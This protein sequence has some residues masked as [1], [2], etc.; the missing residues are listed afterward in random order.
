MYTNE[1]EV[2][3]SQNINFLNMTI[4]QFIT[5]NTNFTLNNGDLPFPIYKKAFKKNEKITAF[6]QTE[7]KVYF[8]ISGIVENN[9]SKDG[10]NKI[11]DFYFSNSFVCSLTSFL[12]QKPSE[13]EI[14]ALTDV[15]VEFAS[16]SDVQK[17]YQNSVLANQLGRHIV[18]Q[19]Y[20]VKFQR[21][22]D[23]LM[24]SAEVRYLELM[25]ARPEILKLLPVNKI[26]Q[27]LGIHAESL[28][29]I[30]KSIIS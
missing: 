9:I 24:K 17:A 20:L 8:I 1:G 30:R 28:S 13:A 19:S 2:K 15:E 29:R 27:Y 23:F 14:I 18:E 11:I 6:G 16:Y 4:K 25:N 21:E 3:A 12:L 5:E 7:S 22:K 10:E 26:A